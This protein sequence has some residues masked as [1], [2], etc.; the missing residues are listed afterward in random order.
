MPVPN[1]G[2]SA[3][4]E[5]NTPSPPTR[6]EMTIT[7]SPNEASHRP[8]ASIKPPIPVV[9]QPSIPPPLSTDYGT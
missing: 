2:T 9:S 1:A 4:A 5:A 6:S 3:S 8:N 7:P